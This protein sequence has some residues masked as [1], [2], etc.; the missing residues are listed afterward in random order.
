MRVCGEFRAGAT[1]R[2]DPQPWNGDPQTLARLWL[3]ISRYGYAATSSAVWA[4]TATLIWWWCCRRR[5]GAY[6]GNGSAASLAI[7]CS[8][9]STTFKA[10]ESVTPSFLCTIPFLFRLHSFSHKSQKF[11]SSATDRPPVTSG[12]RTVRRSLVL[13]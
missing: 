12:Q 13:L 4:Y 3:P 6:I 2:D 7:H 1:P 9:S 10:S 8:Q 11:T 5:G